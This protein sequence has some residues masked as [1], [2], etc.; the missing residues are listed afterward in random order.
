MRAFLYARKRMVN[1]L[2]KLIVSDMDGTLVDDDKNIDTEIFG[3]LPKLKAAGIRFVVASGRQYPSLRDDFREHIGDVV[4]IAENGAFVMDNGKELYSRC[5]TRE[6]VHSCLDSI[7]KV[8]GAL[9]LLCAKTCSYTDNSELYEHLKS[10]LFNY[11]MRLVEDLYAVEDEVIKVSVIE[12]AG[13]GVAHCYGLL[14]PLLDPALNLV[15][16]GATCMDTGIRGINKGT[17]VKALQ[18][19]WGIL[20]EETMVFGDQQNDM[21]MFEQAHYSFAMENAAAEV[22]ARAQY[23]AGSNNS[24]GGVKA[25]REYTGI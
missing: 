12:H 1:T 14:R 16:S 9:P 19:M 5:M 3:L 25:I 7:A 15:V 20:P 23:I 22:K 11:T 8:E 10:P 18:E 2:V 4:V 21:E 13:N 24:G 6:E 17:A